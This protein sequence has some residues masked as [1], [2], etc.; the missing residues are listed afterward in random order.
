MAE[1]LSQNEIDALLAAVSS[2]EIETT[3]NEGGKDGGAQDWVAYDLTSQEK[4]VRGKFVALQGIHERFA[5]LS[6]ITLSA[7]LKKNL[8]VNYIGVDFLR[9]GDYI[10]NILMPTSLSLVHMKNLH[11]YS[12]FVVGSK[13]M[14]ALVDAYYGGSERPY[15]KIGTKEE[16]TS[17]ENQ[18]IH[19]VILQA[20]KD[21]QEAWRLNYPIDLE[22][23]RTESNPHFIGSIHAS[24][25]VTVASFEVEFDNLSGPLILIVQQKALEQIQEVLSINIMGELDKDT[26][27][28]VEHWH[29]EL[30]DL[31]M[32]LSVELGAANRT[33]SEI[34]SFKPGD[35]ITL[36]QDVLSPL[37]INI[38]NQLKFKGIKGT[39]RG[40]SAVKIAEVIPIR[41][42]E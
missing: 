11:G 3:E 35:E 9:F 36:W 2:G 7:M 19:H 32:T 18:L 42:K 12:M 38:Q 28:W 13:L 29:R 22:Y 33:L 27:K 20:I 15:S 10:A 16:F 26:S 40:N 25:L 31:D 23:V 39:Y 41:K 14:Y 6:R 17:I 37:N 1:V 24:D 30:R 4:I 8:S 34:Q 21:M 5:R